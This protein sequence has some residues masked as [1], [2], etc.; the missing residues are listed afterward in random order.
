MPNNLRLNPV[1]V[2]ND[3]HHIVSMKSSDGRV[4]PF[5]AL[6]KLNH[7][8]NALGISEGGNIRYYTFG[9]IMSASQSLAHELITMKPKPLQIAILSES[10]PEFTIVLAAGFLAGIEIIAL[11]THL[12]DTEL[13]SLL[14][15]SQSK[16]L[17]VSKKQEDRSAS[18][19]SLV[20]IMAMETWVDSHRHSP[21]NQADQVYDLDFDRPFLNVF[22]SGTSGVSRMIVISARSLLYQAHSIAERMN[23]SFY[24]QSLSVLPINHLFELA[25]GTLAPLYVGSTVTY[26]NTLMPHEIIALLEKLKITRLVAV[27]LFFKAMKRSIEL[28]INQLPRSKRMITSLLLALAFFMPKSWR[29]KLMPFRKKLGGS[30]QYFGSG[31]A[32]LPPD[33]HEFFDRIGVPVIQGYGLSESSPVLTLN[34]LEGDRRG[35]CGQALV[36]TEIRILNPDERGIGDIIAKGPQLMLGYKDDPGATG[37]VIDDD[38]W[39][40]TGDKGYLDKDGYLFI[41]G[42]SRNIIVLGGGKKVFPEEVE[43]DLADLKLTSEFAVTSHSSGDWE[44]VVLVAVPSPDTRLRYG[45][46]LEGMRSAIHTD[47]RVLLKG[48]AQYKHPARVLILVGN[49]PRTSTHKVKTSQLKSML[50][51]GSFV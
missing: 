40:H 29:A 14:T 39:L 17:I 33:I 43:Q 51:A 50:T 47:A 16:H 37:S 19:E 28:K 15:R 44:E 22:G 10:R 5:L 45:D 23:A 4:A 26:A 34:S 11:D 31:G 8:K 18:F 42:R 24:D 6:W 21:I 32:A 27:P 3:P 9:N 36:D 7:S 20:S 38:G 25:A 12:T 41:T 46:D 13:Q 30:I 49:L 48:T 2:E 1:R 35:S